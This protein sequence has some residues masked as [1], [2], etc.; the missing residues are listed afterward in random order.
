MDP[1]HH[2]VVLLEL[3]PV[4]TLWY[5]YWF[6]CTPLP[7]CTVVLHRTSRRGHR[8][9]LGRGIMRAVRTESNVLSVRR[10]NPGFSGVLYFA[11]LQSRR[12]MC[13]CVYIYF[14][15]LDLGRVKYTYVCN[16][17]ELNKYTTNTIFARCASRGYT[18]W[19]YP[20]IANGSTP[21]SNQ[22]YIAH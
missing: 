5:S 2:T 1:V 22:F 19:Y 7:C 4:H 6:G 16:D 18:F 3:F 17:A 11:R 21:C 10:D 20:H 8:P 12:V 14:R 15:V 13:I 9:P